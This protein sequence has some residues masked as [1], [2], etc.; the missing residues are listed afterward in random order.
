VTP[1]PDDR[2]LVAAAQGGDRRALD[3]LLRRHY[4]LVHAICRRIVGGSRDA[5]DA[6]QEAMISIVR[7]LPRFDGRAAVTT[8]IYRIATNAALDELRRR[9]RRPGLH[10]LREDDRSE[11]EVVD[12][13]GQRRVEGIVDRMSVDAAL[14]QLADEFRVAVVLRDV[15][16]LDYAEI[17]EVLGVPVG[18][19]KSRIAR[20]RSQLVEILGN[21]DA[22]G[23]RPRP[24]ATAEPGSRPPADPDAP[25]PPPTP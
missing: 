11:P 16:D 25:A 7:G 22:A 14:E 20:G 17:A 24:I 19:V 12:P 18:T 1:E 9:K 23:Q 6:T 5:D 4:D 8:W 10:V 2:A 3:T 15:A 21:R 13:L